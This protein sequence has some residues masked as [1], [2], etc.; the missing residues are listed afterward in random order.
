[1]HT[2][3]V[4]KAATMGKAERIP[5]LDL[6][7]DQWL[8]LRNSGIGGSDVS[9]ITG[10]NPWKTPQELAMEKRGELP[11]IDLAENN[12][13]IQWGVILEDVVAREW[14]T[15]KGMSVSRRNA[16]YRHPEHPCLIG[17][18][19]RWIDGTRCGLE[20]KTTG[21]SEGWGE[22]ET[23][24]M[25][26]HYLM[27]CAHYA[28]VLNAEAWYL[29][30]LIGGQELRTYIYERDAELE[31]F[32]ID[33]AVSFWNNHVEKGEPIALDYEAQSALQLINRKYPGTNGQIIS[34]D[35]SFTSVYRDYAAAKEDIKVATKIKKAR[36]A[37]L[38]DIMRDNSIA[39]LPDGL[40]WFTRKEITRKGYEV[41]PTNY[42]DF[43]HTNK[44]PMQP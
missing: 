38:K 18:I 42:I 21:S 34:L 19:D 27:Q 5:T 10:M 36:E 33:K 40:G 23:D 44:E 7:R 2:Y 9:V 31:E 14:A 12:E 25:P 30:V 1:M 22:E 4:T 3:N 24:Q 29:G 17:N 35:E 26:L 39:A 16:M 28:L 6:S 11:Q 43:R 8:Q 41:Q 32:I 15:R 37:A 13:R 20:I